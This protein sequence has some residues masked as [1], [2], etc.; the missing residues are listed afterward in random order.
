MD[1]AQ[2]YTQIPHNLVKS[3][4]VKPQSSS[5]A[6]AFTE[7]FLKNSLQ[8]PS[9]YDLKD[10]LTHKAVILGYARPKK[11]SAKRSSKKAKGLNARQKRKMKIFQI[12][13][14][15]QRYELFL[16][17]HELWR[18]YIVDLCG[19]LKP[20]SNPQFVQQKL[21]K[22]DFHGAIITVVRSKCPSYVGTT[23]ILVQEFK[24]VFK[25]ITK[26]NK[27]K[28]IPKRN[29]VF[30]IEINGFVSHIYGSKFEQRASERSAKKFKVR[31]TIDL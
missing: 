8:K 11:E 19:G 6:A 22:A 17:L 31:G 10:M 4:N 26:E 18:Q 13:P 14:E 7:A 2:I 15:H 29:S 12:K 24:H 21:L 23:G 5:K 9:Q 27:L 28:V 3:L 30:A 1:E 25:I 16:P 20:T